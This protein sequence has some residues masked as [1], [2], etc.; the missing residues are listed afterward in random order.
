MNASVSALPTVHTATAPVSTRR[1]P[2]AA[3]LKQQLP[4]STPLGAQVSSQRQAI[5]AILNGE[6]SRLL[7]AVKRELLRLA[8]ELN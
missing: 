8:P 2:T 6:D 3:Q 7:V 4:L 5:R 1:L